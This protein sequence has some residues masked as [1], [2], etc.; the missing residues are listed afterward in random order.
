MSLVLVMAVN[1][2]HSDPEKDQRGCYKR[3][4]VVEVFEDD[5]H[6][7]DLVAN[8]IMAP[9]AMVRI[10]SGAIGSLGA[11]VTPDATV[12]PLSAGQGGQSI[13]PPWFAVIGD[14]PFSGTGEVVMTS[15][16]P[17][18]SRTTRRIRSRSDSMS[19]TVRR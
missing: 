17:S 18:E 15:V 3:G 12:I 1:H 11:A 8:P 2:T 10:R 14:Q 6:T 7:G 13:N 16:A 19:A 9:F 5:A 4:D